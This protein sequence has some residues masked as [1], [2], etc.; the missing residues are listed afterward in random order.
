MK[1][2]LLSILVIGILL[3]GACGAP[4]AP[5]VEAPP[6]PTIYTFSVS[7]SPSGAGSVSPSGSQYEE[8]TQ[9]TLTA[10]PTSGYT[11]DYWDG[12]ASGSSATITITMDSDK[13]IIAHFADTTPPVV[14][15]VDISH[16][17][18]SRAI[19]TWETDELTTSQVEYGR[20]DAYGSIKTLDGELTASHSVTLTEL[21]PETAYHFRVKSVDEAGNEALS[22]DHTFT[23]KTTKELLS[24][25]L[26][27]GIT[28]GGRVHQLSFNLFNGSSQTITV[29]KVEIF[30]EHGDV[31][32]TMSKSD[33]VETWGSGEVDVGQSL[34]AGISFGIPP[35]TTE[36]EDWQVKWYCLDTNGVKFTVE[37]KYSQI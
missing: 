15:G 32:F 3:L 8:G 11:F 26:Y 18:E 37:G 36:V 22:D 19:I 35:S 29:T 30:D 21:K 16:I 6:V 9:V 10:T 33:I 28:I 31:A 34:S 12:D 17:T 7:V 13:S 27:S 24:P 5:P 23:T 1:R 2:T 20:S 4:T 25:M 14:L